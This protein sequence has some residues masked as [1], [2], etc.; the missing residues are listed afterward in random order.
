MLPG[1]FS[2]QWLRNQ[3]AHSRRQVV[4]DC[5]HANRAGLLIEQDGAAEGRDGQLGCLAL[6]FRPFCPEAALAQYCP[7]GFVSGSCQSICL[8]CPHQGSVA[9]ATM[10]AVGHQP[11]VHLGAGALGFAAATGEATG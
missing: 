4:F 6:R 7:I 5:I 11:A 1:E 8:Q 3:W 10:G 9:E 2:L